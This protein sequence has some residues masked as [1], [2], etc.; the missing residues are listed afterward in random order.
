MSLEKISLFGEEYIWQYISQRFEDEQ[1]A[2][3]YRIYVTDALQLISEN[4]ARFAGGKVMGKRYYEIFDTGQDEP[5][6]TS[7]DVIASISRQLDELS[8]K[9]GEQQ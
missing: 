8:R 9:E 4:T 1:K 2:E 7:E 6:R 3:I 5:Q